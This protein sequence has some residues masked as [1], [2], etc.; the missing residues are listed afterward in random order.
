MWRKVEDKSK[1]EKMAT[2]DKKR[3]ADELEKFNKV[4][5]IF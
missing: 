1:W 3:Y 4:S 2:D 5:W